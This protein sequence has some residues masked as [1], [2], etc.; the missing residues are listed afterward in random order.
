MYD[1]G[2]VISRFIPVF[3]RMLKREHRAVEAIA[4]RKPTHYQ[5][6]GEI[7]FYLAEV[8]SWKA[9]RDWSLAQGKI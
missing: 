4:D 1:E 6:L 5:G 3:T 9:D 2:T 8:R 7:A